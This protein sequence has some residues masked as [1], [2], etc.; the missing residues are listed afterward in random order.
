MIS[1]ELFVVFKT[2]FLLFFRPNYITYIQKQNSN[3][4]TDFQELFCDIELEIDWASKAFDKKPDAVN[5]W[6]GDSRA[7]TSSNFETLL[8]IFLCN[9]FCF[10][11]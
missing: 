5:F 4:T 1:S 7:I 10:S 2:F 3:L 6:L 9:N 11:A 8:S